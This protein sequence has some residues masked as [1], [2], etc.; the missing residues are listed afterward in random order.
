MADGWDSLS[1]T[2]P[3][4]APGWNVDPT[5]PRAGPPVPGYARAFAAGQRAANPTSDAWEKLSA[6]PPAKAAPASL[7]P[8]RSWW[9]M[10][11]ASEAVR[12]LSQGAGQVIDGAGGL[13]GMVANPLNH[14][15][16]A[17]LPG[18]PVSTHVGEG[19][20][21]ALGFAQ[22]QTRGERLAGDVISGGAAGLLSFGA[23]DAGLAAAKAPGITRSFLQFLADAPVVNTVAGGTG[24]G[25]SGVAR[26]AGYGPIGQLIAGLAGGVVGGVGAHAIGGVGRPRVVAPDEQLIWG[27]LD[28][29]AGPQPALPNP[30]ERLLL[31]DQRPNAAPIALPD[32]NVMRLPAPPR[33]LPDLRGEPMPPVNSNRP[34]PVGRP[35]AAETPDVVQVSAPRDTAEMLHAAEQLRAVIG[36]PEAFA[37][38]SRL[39]A[40]TSDQRGPIDVWARLAQRAPANDTLNL[41]H[42][43][44]APRPDAP[45]FAPARPT[46]GIGSRSA[47]ERI[48][49]NT[50]SG[51]RRYGAD[52]RVITSPKGAQGE[53]QVMPATARDPGYG[54][55]PSDGSLDDTARVGRELLAKWT[56]HYGGDPAKGWAAYNGGPGRLDRALRYGDDW[57]SHMPAETRAYVQKNMKALGGRDAA[58]RAPEL[59]E[60][61]AAAPP[62][63]PR[64]E[65]TAVPDR[66]TGPDPL[67]ATPARAPEPARVSTGDLDGPIGRA[68]F[69]PHEIQA[70]AKLMQFKEGGDEFGVTDRLRGV[71]QWEPGFEKP[72]MVWEGADGRRL[73]AD[74]HQRLGLAKRLEAEGHDPI[75]LQAKVL[76]EADGWHPHDARSL[77][78]LNNMSEGSGTSMDAAKVIRDLGEERF[79]RW[80]DR[81]PQRGPVVREGRELAKLSD[82]AFGAVVNDVVPPEHGAAIARALPHSPDAHMSMVK[83]LH[84]AD[85]ANARQAESIVRQAVE[86]GWHDQNPAEQMSMFGGQERQA[87]LYKVKAQIVDD[88]KRSLGGKARL[89]GT[90]AKEGDTLARVGNRIEQEASAKEST[91]NATAAQLVDRLAT[92]RGNPIADALHDAAVSVAGGAKRAEAVRGFVEHVRSLDHEALARS[93]GEDHPR[94]APNDRG[95][96][97]G[98]AAA[99]EDQLDAFGH[100]PGDE[101]AALERAG[102]GRDR[103]DAA[104]K[105][106]GSD[107]G[108]FDAPEAHQDAPG[109]FD[110]NGGKQATL[111]DTA[112]RTRLGDVLKDQTDTKGVDDMI[113]RG[114]MERA[115][116]ADRARLTDAGR[117]MLYPKLAR[118][119]DGESGFITADMLLAPLRAAGNLVDWKGLRGDADAILR[120]MREAAGDPNKAL[121][122]TMGWMKRFGS[123]A[124]YSADGSARSLA[125]HFGSPTLTK[126]A[127][128]FHAEAGK[129]SGTAR[130]Y[131]EAIDRGTRTRIQQ[132][133]DALEPHMKDKAAL[134][135]VRDLLATPRASMSATAAEWTAAGKIRD[136]LKETLDYRR[137]AGEDLGEVSD[138]Y[139]PRVIEPALVAK[140]PV[141][142]TRQATTLYRGIGLSAKDASN[143]A[144]A[145]TLRVMD[146]YGGIDGGLD[147]VKG[148]SNPSSGKS[149]EFGKAADTAMKEFYQVDPFLTLSNYVQGSVKRA[150]QNRRFGA[151]GAVGSPER[152]AWE[153]AH[154]G[155][156]QWD[157]MLETI[158]D[159]VRASGKEAMGVM[160]RVSDLKA[161]NL[162]QIAP[163]NRYSKSV[164]SML[165]TYNQ[166]A[167]M[168]RVTISS[169]GDLTMGFV[170]G[171]PKYGFQHLA[172]SLHQ[173]GRQ[174]MKMK[175]DE[176]TRYAEAIGT[177]NDAFGSAV[178]LARTD[179]NYMGAGA[180]KLIDNFYRGVGLQQLTDAG[181]IAATKTGQ[182]FISELSHDLMSTDARTKT[183]AGG[184]LR[185]LGVK[186]P[187]AFGAQLRASKPTPD[188]ILGDRGFPADYATA[189]MRYVNQS[190]IMPSRAQKP[191]W[192]NH[193]LGNLF[194]ALQGYSYG[195]KKN[196]LDRVGRE[197]AAAVKE[198]DP[199]KLA[200]ASG[201][202]VLVGMQYLNDTYLR[203]AIFGSN[204]DFASETPLQAGVR[205][206]DRAGILG[207][208]SP[209]W[210]AFHPTK[211]NKGPVAALAGPIFG[212]LEDPYKVG[213][214]AVADNPNTNSDERAAAGALY[215]AVIEPAADG[216]AAA[217][218]RGV[219]RTP[220]ILFTG[221]RASNGIL[222][223]DREAF[224]NAVGGVKPEPVEAD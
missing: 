119:I 34:A 215:D 76:R 147:H 145:W 105:P 89:F 133:Y 139:F 173:F 199:T 169:L 179:A 10:P 192:A 66:A 6:A 151:A 144:D 93:G 74:G 52:G 41:P 205:T 149:R 40:G 204:Y 103:S 38:R 8:K 170:R 219:A 97:A 67:A 153:K 207:P 64:R 86:D 46:A 79:G 135:R 108:L 166:L 45:R 128:L 143:A 116:G 168:D 180:P 161:S 196:V 211:Y 104:Q 113:A 61:A 129:A 220:G 209:V 127:D 214:W 216:L 190:I 30:G 92:R 54:I 171:G 9:E 16:N 114:L 141:K 115:D 58:P 146:S 35:N 154:P 84:E 160:D 158:R 100:R 88:A 32:G 90:A 107:G 224:I 138:G 31:T 184:Y 51:G 20:G 25:A 33:A 95:G 140:D 137:A 110:H 63:P 175:P 195:F 187:D 81:L 217:R 212:R 94:V 182:R 162:G 73:V 27:T 101:R 188:D 194:F 130:T 132:I 80:T 106:P 42:V 111:G 118:A 13:V 159:E 47:I 70:D 37:A 203:P 7:S 91:A 178:M 36:D 85:P 43:P 185:E 221:Q 210:N 24:G 44:E 11:S 201:L 191:T 39:L 96:E 109:L 5:P 122:S 121:G 83:L 120:T 131:E 2:P 78:A 87:S 172:E 197:T 126:F 3:A 174:I 156:S 18:Q 99:G 55:R 48:T 53:M 200:A 59:A 14:I 150:E 124:L 193:P 72:V 12:R 102:E 186:D 65:E 21:E 4:R 68:E 123:L 29:T 163:T 98:L 77:A 19:W 28:P 167:V 164:V 183:R 177:A 62:S 202:A 157:V 223:S 60:P 213:K 57:L 142:F 136:V 22:P 125:D 75:T 117:K 176:A 17:A 152:A 71:T 56:D 26:E 82:E 112:D 49:A 206:I 134:S 198:R 222:P 50:E 189:V 181:R 218:L 148:S 69:R 23:A 15:V 1:K 165:H 208:L 155:Q